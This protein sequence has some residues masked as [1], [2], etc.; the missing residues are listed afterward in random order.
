MM[1]HELFE[2]ITLADW[3]E[4]FSSHDVGDVFEPFLK[5][6]LEPTDGWSG[7]GKSG[8]GKSIAQCDFKDIKPHLSG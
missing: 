5:S 4:F 2:I 1:L 3:I 8:T 6:S 7:L